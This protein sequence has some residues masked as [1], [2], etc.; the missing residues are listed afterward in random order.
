RTDPEDD[1]YGEI[2][3]LE[4]TLARADRASGLALER[5]LRE[6][7]VV[8]NRGKQTNWKPKE[9]CGAVK[10]E[11]G[12]LKE[13][14]KAYVQASDADLAWALRDD[15][16]GFLDAYERAKSQHAVVDYADLLLRAR[17][18]LV[19]SIPVRRYSQRRFDFIL[20]AE[21][22]DTDP[23]QAQIAFLLAE[24]PEAPPAAD[25]RE[26]RLS[27][28]KLFVVGD[29][30]QSIYRFRRAD[31][32][33][34]DEVKRLVAAS[35]G[36]VL[37]LTANFRTVPSILAFVNERFRDV[38]GH[39]G[40]PE[41]RDLDPYR[42]EV[43]SQGARTVPLPLP[44][45]RLPEV[46]DRTVASIR[47]VLAATVAG[48]IDDITRVRPWSI[49]DRADDSVRPARPGDVGLLVRKM[50]PEC[51]GPFVEELSRQGI[52]YRLVGGSEY[53]A[54]EEVQA[55]TAVLR[56]IDNPTDKLAVFAALRSPFF[57]LSDD[58][59]FQFVASGGKLN[60]LAPI[61]E[62]VRNADLVGP[63]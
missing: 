21:F 35:G 47:P 33:I 46:D 49:R 17:D 43:G 11:L 22:Q 6:L 40:D 45:D 3:R 62:G 51:I 39:P 2:L 41:P 19:R 42:P 61:D 44:K 34:Y 36:E 60:P 27:P 32:A 13:A 9:A 16:R 56:A 18:V 5:L 14:Q 10:A 29:P 30:K 59:V 20:V 54:R 7:Y 31:I 37:P 38:F 12:A 48:F 8:P 15:L 28:G 52:L 55:L 50:T 53:Y 63:I 57:G 1:A 26:V 24:D 4:A 58:D 23:L 25:W